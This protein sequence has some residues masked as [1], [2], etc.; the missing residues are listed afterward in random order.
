MSNYTLEDFDKYPDL[1]KDADDGKYSDYEYGDDD[2]IP[3][4]EGEE[5]SSEGETYAV[6]PTYENIWLD[7]E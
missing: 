2:W 3:D 4:P 6:E 1:L 7:F 5:E